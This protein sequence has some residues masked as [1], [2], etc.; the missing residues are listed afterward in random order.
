M[1]KDWS[2]QERQKIK[3]LEKQVKQLTEDKDQ[4]MY[5]TNRAM[6]FIHSDHYHVVDEVGL[7]LHQIRER[8]RKDVSG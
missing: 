8:Y 7:I 3:E 5:A 2:Y 1:D 4:L 6:T